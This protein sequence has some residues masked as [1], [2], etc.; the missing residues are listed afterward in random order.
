LANL[1]G[2][3]ADAERDRGFPDQAIQIRQRQIEFLQQL[4]TAHPANVDFRVR[5]IPA[6]EGLGILLSSTRGPESGVEQLR[7]AVAEAERL[8][9]IEPENSYWKGLGAQARLDLAGTLLQLGQVAEA[10]TYAS[11][12]CDLAAQVL[13]RDP[14]PAWRHLRT[15]CLMTRSDLA[16]KAGSYPEA[17]ALAQEALAAARIESSSDPVADRYSIADA[18]R[19]IGD[20]Y[21]RMGDTRAADTA[22]AAAFA[23]L[24]QNV[25]E[26]PSEIRE[27]AGLLERLGH[28][29]EARTLTELLR[30]M[31]YGRTT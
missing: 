23:Q 5:Q 7:L 15:T 27:R 18:Y 31:G 29:G 24:P 6:H 13:S 8:I 30:K 3:T 1:L 16:S 11:G 26:R 2:W 28:G 19:L 20:I 21:Q 17:M 9:P 22:W 10:E 4:I 14:G 12:G 25:T